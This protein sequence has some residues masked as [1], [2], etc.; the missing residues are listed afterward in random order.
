MSGGDVFAFLFVTV[1]ARRHRPDMTPP[2]QSRRGGR[3]VANTT[4]AIVCALALAVALP[5]ATVV[6]QTMRPRADGLLEIADA[7][8]GTV[9]RYTLDGTEPTRDA[10]VWLAP[11]GVPAGYTVKARARDRPAHRVD[12]RARDARTGLARL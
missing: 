7:P 12:T 10:G 8:P 2:L 5:A 3:A 6:A 11:V 9:V 1:P 4:N